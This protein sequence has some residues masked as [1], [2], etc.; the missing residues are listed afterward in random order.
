MRWLWRCL[1][2]NRL[3]VATSDAEALSLC[4]TA[5]LSTDRPQISSD[6]PLDS[7]LANTVQNET[8]RAAQPSV[9]PLPGCSNFVNVRGIKPQSYSILIDLPE[10][11]RI[12]RV[13]FDF[14]L[15]L[16][17]QFSTDCIRPPA[18]ISRLD[19]GNWPLN[20]RAP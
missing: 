2:L 20:G 5:P 6:E 7:S 12:M 11:R 19:A 3:Q 15:D 13:G 10:A 16:K 1:C 8:D 14:S 9:S 17:I 18:A 4:G